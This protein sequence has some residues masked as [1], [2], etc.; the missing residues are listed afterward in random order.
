MHSHS[1]PDDE[2]KERAHLKR[3]HGGTWYYSGKVPESFI[4]RLRVIRNKNRVRERIRQGQKRHQPG[5][6][7]PFFNLLLTH[8]SVSYITGVK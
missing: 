5:P 6:L 2:D 4:R 3:I 8:I 7:N 1:L